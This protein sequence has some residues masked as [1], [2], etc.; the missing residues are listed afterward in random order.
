MSTLL[1]ETR[2]RST[3]ALT[4]KAVAM[5]WGVM[6]RWE[7]RLLTVLLMNWVESWRAFAREQ[8]LEMKVTAVKQ[9]KQ[10]E[11]ATSS[12]NRAVRVLR[13][14]VRRWE[15]SQ[16]GI[17]LHDWASAMERCKRQLAVEQQLSRAER[18]MRGVVHRWEGKAVGVLV[19]S[20]RWKMGAMKEMG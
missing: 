1:S 19:H 9:Q 20:W 18:V 8:E 2:L 13:S 11:A 14:A 6:H 7:G 5:L 17:L 3:L 12:H 10:Y 16:L 15:G 4:P